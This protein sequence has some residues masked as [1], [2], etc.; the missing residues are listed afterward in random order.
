MNVREQGV[1]RLFGRIAPH[2]D[3]LNTIISFGLHRG[4]RRRALRLLDPHPGDLCLD[5]AAGTG[6]FAL[7]LA[8]LGAR[9]VALDM[10]LEMLAVARRR[11]PDLWIVA[12]DAFHLPFADATFDGVTAGF[13]FRHAKDDLPLILAEMRRV[14]KP[15]GR[16]VSLEL[17]HPPGRLWRRL[18]DL[19]IQ[20]LLPV[21]GGFVDRDAYQYLADSLH[22]YPDAPQLADLFRQAGFDRCDFTLL[23]GG[24]AAIH[25]ASVAGAREARNLDTAFSD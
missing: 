11:A 15:G 6:D 5:V 3:L 18:S 14:L 13:G 25:V 1:R 7:R 12:G 20:L 4:W 23:A 9:P 21:I 22:G 24:V 17:S 2:Y 10:T 8:R 16:C 19:Y